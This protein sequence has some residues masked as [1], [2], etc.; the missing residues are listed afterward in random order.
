MKRNEPNRTEIRTKLK[1]RNADPA[2][3]PS[4][5][6]VYTILL[7]SRDQQILVQAPSFSSTPGNDNNNGWQKNKH[8]KLLENP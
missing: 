7:E 3:P 5:A 6:D 8:K 1:R 2:T 4:S